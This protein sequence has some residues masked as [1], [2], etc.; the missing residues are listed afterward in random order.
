MFC[1][2]S[3][4]RSSVFEGV[5]AAAAATARCHQRRLWWHQ[6]AADA[7]ASLAVGSACCEAEDI[8][9]DLLIRC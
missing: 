5:A 6:S 9:N 8:S 7:V 1:A 4:A 3:V 2:S